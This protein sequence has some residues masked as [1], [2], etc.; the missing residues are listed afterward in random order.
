MLNDLK[1]QQSRSDCRKNNPQQMKTILHIVLEVSISIVL[2]FR[3]DQQVQILA[4]K[5]KEGRKKERRQKRS[6]LVNSTASVSPTQMQIS[7]TTVL[8]SREKPENL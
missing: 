2:A 5:W 8:N 1:P 4:G 6:S 7:F 3:E